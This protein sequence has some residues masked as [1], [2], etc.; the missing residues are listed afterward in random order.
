MLR[1]IFF[2]TALFFQTNLPGMFLRFLSSMFAGR[3]NTGWVSVWAP[4]LLFPTPARLTTTP[5]AVSMTI[6]QHPCEKECAATVFRWQDGARLMSSKN[7][8]DVRM[9]ISSIQ[10]KSR[11]RVTLPGL[12]FRIQECTCHNVRHASQKVT[13]CGPDNWFKPEPGW[14]RPVLF[15]SLN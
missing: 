3:T 6:N 1:C 12:T 5:S 8:S 7:S 14:E 10:S 9:R 13:Q 4:G 2:D 15:K 11:K